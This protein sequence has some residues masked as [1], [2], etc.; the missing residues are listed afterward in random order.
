VDF[1]LLKTLK[2]NQSQLELA[3]A[4]PYQRHPFFRR[5]EHFFWIAGALAA[6]WF[7]LA[8]LGIVSFQVTEAKRLETLP[9]GYPPTQA[10]EPGDPFGR[11]SIPRI[12]LSAI[13]AEGD[14]EATL[15]NAVGHIP[16]SA[17]PWGTGNVA[18]TGN[19]DTFFRGLSRLR[20]DDVILLET[21]QGTYRYRVVRITVADSRNVEVL[22][23]PES[24]LTLVTSYPIHYTGSAPQTYI[25]QG[26]RL[27]SA[28]LPTQ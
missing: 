28:R 15:R 17:S 18:L 3:A 9:Q 6:G 11:I 25:V 21:P 8:S 20:L 26:M 5:L 4:R 22:R 10:L 14:D 23:S 19:R 27:L 12:G 13:I 24:D 2:R 16:G 1:A 7:V